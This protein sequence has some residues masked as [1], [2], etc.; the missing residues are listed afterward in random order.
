MHCET[1]LRAF[2]STLSTRRTS[3]QGTVRPLTWMTTPLKISD[4]AAID[5]GDD[6][7]K[8]NGSFG[9]VARRLFS[10]RCSS[11]C[12]RSLAL[13]TAMYVP[14]SNGGGGGFGGAGEGKPS[15]LAFLLP[16][17][18]ARPGPSCIVFSRWQW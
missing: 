16:R 2:S 1:A 10:A 9:P 18:S 14:K 3:A 6:D 17:S 5:D 7:D 4:V 12:T 13:L 11:N 15:A 8:A